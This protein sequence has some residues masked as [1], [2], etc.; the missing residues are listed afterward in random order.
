MLQSPRYR[1][2]LTGQV[3]NKAAFYVGKRKILNTYVY[4]LIWHEET[5]DMYSRN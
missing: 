1:D 2:K 4:I 3:K 5:L